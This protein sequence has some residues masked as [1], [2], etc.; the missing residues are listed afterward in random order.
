MYKLKL[1]F[2]D[3]LFLDHIGLPHILDL[4]VHLVNFMG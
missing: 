3:K 2:I 4:A 1:G